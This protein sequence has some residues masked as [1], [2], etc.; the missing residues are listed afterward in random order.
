MISPIYTRLFGLILMIS[1]DALWANAQTGAGYALDFDGVND[2][3]EIKDHSSLNPRISM[4]VEAWIYPTA[5]AT[6]VWENSILCKHNWASGNKGYVLRC[7]DGG[8]VSFNICSRSS[9]SWV[10]AQSSSS[11]LDLNKWYH[12]AG[13]FDGDS[14]KVYVNGILQAFT[15]YT[16]LIDISTGGNARIGQLST[17]NGRNFN[18]MID[19]VRLWDTAID[20]K[21]M[22]TWMCQRLNSSHKFAARLVGHWKMDEGTG[23]TLADSSA[24]SNSGSLNGPYWRV[25]GAAIGDRSVFTYNAKELNIQSKQGDQ[26]KINKFSGSPRYAH[27]YEVQGKSMAQLDPNVGGDLDTTHYYGLYLDEN[28]SVTANATLYYSANKAYSGSNDCG[29]DLFRR[30][31]GDSMFWEASGTKVYLS[32]DSLLTE[33]HN[34]SEFALVNYAMDSNTILRTSNGK[35]WYCKGDSV[36]L[37]AAG[38][39]NFRYTWF[40]NGTQIKG[41]TGN[42]IYAS[43]VGKY[44]VEAVRTGTTC[45]V[46]SIEYTISERT[47]PKV[48]LAAQAPVCESV[49]TVVLKGGSPAGGSYLGIT[50][51]DSLFF[52][53]AVGYGRYNIIYSYTDTALCTSRDTQTLTVWRLPVLSITGGAWTCDNVD[54]FPLNSVSPSG[55]TYFGKGISSNH[56]FPD[57]VNG[58]IGMYGYSYTYT[59]TNK[60]SNTTSDSIELRKSTIAILNPIPNSC[61]NTNPLNLLGLPKGGTFSGPGVNGSSFDPDIAGVGTHTITYRYVNAVG[62]PSYNS[63]TASVFKGS[64]VSWNFSRSVCVNGDSLQLPQG[65]PSGGSFSGRGVI[66]DHFFPSNAG[67]GKHIL[68]YTYTDS[69]KCSNEASGNME[70][71]DTTALTVTGIPTVCP[72]DAPVKLVL[73][74]PSG[75][76][77]TGSAVSRDSFFVERAVSGANRVDYSYTDMNGCIS[78]IKLE[79]E[80]LKPGSASVTLPESVCDGADPLKIVVNP[81][82]GTLSGPAIIGQFFVPSSAGVGTHSILYAY[83]DPSG[84]TVRDTANITVAEVPNVTLL[85]QPGI[86]ANIEPFGLKGGMPVGGIYKLNGLE[87]QDFEPSEWQIGE[88]ELRYIFENEWSCSDSA[89]IHFRMHPLPPKPSV[90]L[91]DSVLKSTSATGNQW[92]NSAGEIAGATG[93]SYRPLSNGSYW[94]VVASDSGCTQAS[95]TFMYDLI[96]IE[97]LFDAGIELFPVPCVS[98]L[99]VRSGFR[100]TYRLSDLAGRTV[101]QGQFERELNALDVSALKNGCYYLELNDGLFVRYTRF[102]ISR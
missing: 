39:S 86:C 82:G 15:L 33:R 54:S 2:Y 66:R 79:I 40:Y 57:S 28:T 72:G 60:C 14:V 47:P 74:S 18:G 91:Q 23:T 94:V 1:A 46:K 22:Q 30:Y 70:V 95:D 87:K 50:V 21:T 7:G 44:Q 37:I 56:F 34:V 4:T 61:L 12:V 89:T 65:N 10:E 16:G 6:N 51:R 49:D 17:G 24:N 5:F 68:K 3:V 45:S 96:G 77:Y 73:V 31:P 99:W 32:G 92:Y 85:G 62:C 98:T 8:R 9:G 52:P 101:G 76:T 97:S 93:Q 41:A 19:E 27:L 43:K 13:V 55:G 84:C 102:T 83:A 35:P 75:G 58:I 88:Q 11:V 29:L 78:S 100:A 90:L 48:S 26:L 67:T 81:T 71:F 42:S 80:K 63:K 25:S 53:S 20:V 69:N 59:D 36:R 38:N 64:N